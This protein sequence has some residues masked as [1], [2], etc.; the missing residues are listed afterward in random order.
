MFSTTV[1]LSL[2]AGKMVYFRSLFS[3]AGAFLSSVV[4]LEGGAFAL[5]RMADSFNHSCS[6]SVSASLLFLMADSVAVMRSTTGIC[7]GATAS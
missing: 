1:H 7:S 6:A 3:D 2:S 4:R 5:E